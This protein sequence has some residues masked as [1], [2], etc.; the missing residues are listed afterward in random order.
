M[1]AGGGEKMTLRLVA[2]YG[3]ACNIMDSPEVAAHK[4][5]VLEKH[6]KDVDRDNNTINRTVTTLAL[7]ADTNQKARDLILHPEPP[8]R[9]P[10]RR[11]LVWSD[12][13]GRHARKPHRRLPGRRC[14]GTHHQLRRPQRG[15]GQSDSPNYSS[16]QPT[17]VRRAWAHR[18]ASTTTQG[19][20]ALTTPPHPTTADDQDPDREPNQPD[21]FWRLEAPDANRI[22]G[23][24]AAA[25]D[26]VSSAEAMA[27]MYRW[28]SLAQAWCSSTTPGICR[29]SPSRFGC[30]DFFSR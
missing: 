3:D 18:S 19:N 11:R 20:A 1:I 13:H 25:H 29:Y 26:H 7:I 9:L 8:R 16:K 5:A 2:R 10:G 12:R 15:A 17:G 22:S 28:L 27:A 21:L 4:F 30:P 23:G 14:A 24:G 6:C